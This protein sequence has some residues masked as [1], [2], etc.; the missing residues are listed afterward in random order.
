MADKQE[1]KKNYDIF[2]TQKKILNEL[3]DDIE[4]FV[5]TYEF[6]ADNENTDIENIRAKAYAALFSLEYKED[7]M[8]AF[9]LDAKARMPESIVTR[10]IG[11]CK[12]CGAPTPSGM[13]NYCNHCFRYIINEN[14]K[15]HQEETAKKADKSLGKYNEAMTELKDL[16]RWDKEQILNSTNK[17]RRERFKELYGIDPTTKE[18]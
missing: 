4:H 7:D 9:F 5:G 10:D 14:T 15:E 1:P 13:I 6:L 2:G 11:K 8:K 12:N 3:I 18:E 16:L 17:T